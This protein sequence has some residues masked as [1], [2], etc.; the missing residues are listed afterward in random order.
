MLFAL[1][2][3]SV[4][5]KDHEGISKIWNLL[6]NPYYL[7]TRLCSI[8]NC[9]VAAYLPSPSPVREFFS[10]L[11]TPLIQSIWFFARCK[12]KGARI[13]I[14]ELT[15]FMN[16][17]FRNSFFSFILPGVSLTSANK[18]FFKNLLQFSLTEYFSIYP[19]F[20]IIIVWKEH[21]HTFHVCML[22]TS[23]V[24]FI[25]KKNVFIA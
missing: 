7:L 5:R 18:N 12:M 15:S 16:N 6:N 10:I 24:F 4:L 3:S 22:A 17:P 14:F 8:E 1:F 2:D 13:T 9:P 20:A 19:G 23:K 25:L 11:T 21:L